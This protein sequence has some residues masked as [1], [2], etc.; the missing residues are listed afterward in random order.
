M[1]TCSS[2]VGMLVFVQAVPLSGESPRPALPNPSPHWASSSCPGCPLRLGTNVPSPFKEAS[3]AGLSGP[4]ACLQHVPDAPRVTC[5][6][7]QLFMCPPPSL[8][9]GGP[10]GGRYWVLFLSRSQ[11]LAN[12]IGSIISTAKHIENYVPA[13]YLYSLTQSSQRP[14]EAGTTSYSVRT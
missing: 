10:L 7:S 13:I 11:D 8:E 4:P 1:R 14:S 6:Y 9:C 3:Q 2:A 5:Y 12:S